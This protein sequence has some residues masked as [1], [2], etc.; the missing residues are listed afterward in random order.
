MSTEPSTET[1]P[2]ATTD[3]PTAPASSLPRKR[4]DLAGNII[5]TGRRKSAIARVRLRSGAGV[6]TVNKR[7]L[8]VYFPCLKDREQVPGALGHVGQ[9]KTVDVDITVSGGGATGQSGACRLG[10]TSSSFTL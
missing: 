5:A 2:P 10:I 1:L 6:I 9:E 7:P 3:V 4:V 8:D